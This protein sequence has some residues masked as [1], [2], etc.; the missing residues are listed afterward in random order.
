MDKLNKNGYLLL[1]NSLLKNE[2]NFGK[3]CFNNIK[4][5]YSNIELFIKNTFFT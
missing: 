5:N 2:I 1:K 4:V 3:K